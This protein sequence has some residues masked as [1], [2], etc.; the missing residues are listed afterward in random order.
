MHGGIRFDYTSGKKRRG[1]ALSELPEPE[2]LW[3]RL[4]SGQPDLILAA[5]RTL[6]REEQEIIRRHLQTMTRDEGWH[7][8]QRR[9]AFAALQ[10]LDE[11]PDE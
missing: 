7:P 3:S 1:A 10:C 11:S 8:G 4:L 2:A 5:W 9:A 6:G